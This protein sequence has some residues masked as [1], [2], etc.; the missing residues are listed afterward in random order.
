MKFS[1]SLLAKLQLGLII[2]FTLIFAFWNVWQQEIAFGQGLA[3]AGINSLEELYTAMDNTH[4]E[5]TLQYMSLENRILYSGQQPL[6]HTIKAVHWDEKFR[7]ETDTGIIMGYNGKNL[8]M[9]TRADNTITSVDAEGIDPQEVGSIPDIQW[10]RDTFGSDNK[11]LDCHDRRYFYL[12]NFRSAKSPHF[13]VAV[14]KN[15]LQI[16]EMRTFFSNG[17]LLVTKVTNTKPRLPDETSHEEFDPVSEASDSGK[18]Y[19]IWGQLGIAAMQNERLD[20]AQDCFTKA[21]ESHPDPDLQVSYLLKWGDC[22][23]LKKDFAPALGKYQ[24]AVAV[25][26]CLPASQAIAWHREGWALA[27][28][29]KNAE[30]I[31]ALNAAATLDNYPDI[32]ATYETLGLVYSRMGDTENCRKA[33]ELCITKSNDIAQKQRIQNYLIQLK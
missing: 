13:I 19:L 21:L 18:P 24:E 28:Q 6:T 7:V 9:Y 3:T 20:A 23:S 5:N 29:D 10:L 1:S 12:T 16:D 15:T 22:F 30:A 33:L 17:S 8:W 26:G 11:N 14:D 27:M 2:L 25:Q 32:A 31:Q 4:K